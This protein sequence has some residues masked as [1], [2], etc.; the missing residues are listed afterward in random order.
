MSDET[1]SLLVK[2]QDGT[3][4]KI[5]GIPAAAKVTFG[6][7]QPG[8]D[9]FGRGGYALRIYTTQNNQLAVFTDVAE[10]RDLSLSVETRVVETKGKS[11]KAVL[12][13]EVVQSSHESKQFE[14]WQ[15]DLA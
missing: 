2:L 13:G 8:E 14:A 15:E 7:V 5:H 12:E 9:R 10:F 3:Q 1:R 11:R 4:K 6:R